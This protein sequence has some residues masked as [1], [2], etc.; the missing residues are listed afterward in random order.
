METVTLTILELALIG[1]SVILLFILIL[2]NVIFHYQ[3]RI[4]NYRNKLFV[5]EEGLKALGLEQD[6]LVKISNVVKALDK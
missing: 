5:C 3:R 1:F 6:K 2:I 4:M